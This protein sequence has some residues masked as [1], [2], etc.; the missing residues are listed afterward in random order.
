MCHLYRVTKL[1]NFYGSFFY[2]NIFSFISWDKFLYETRVLDNSYL[3]LKVEL[4]TFDSTEITAGGPKI[5]LSALGVSHVMRSINV[6]YLLTYLLTL[7][8]PV[9]LDTQSGKIYVY[10]MRVLYHIYGVFTSSLLALVVSEILGRSEIY[11]RGP[12]CPL[13]ETVLYPRRVLYYI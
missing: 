8:G 9:S 2:I 11:T 3:W 1:L 4:P 10:R 5:T 6:R 13:V 7:E 12:G